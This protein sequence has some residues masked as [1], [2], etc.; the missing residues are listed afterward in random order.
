MPA[1]ALASYDQWL[2]AHPQDAT[3]AAAFNGR[4]WARGQLNRELGQALSDCNAALKLTPGNPAYLDSRGLIR[5]RRGEFDAA[6]LDYT[7]P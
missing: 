7:P 2:R 5:L 3:R 6:L 1:A 4:C